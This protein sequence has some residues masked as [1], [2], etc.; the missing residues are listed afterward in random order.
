V[1]VRRSL[2]N[3]LRAREGVL[4]WFLLRSLCLGSEWRVSQKVLVCVP[5]ASLNTGAEGAR[6]DFA[7]GAYRVEI[8]RAREASSD[9]TDRISEMDV[10]V[11]C[12]TTR[13]GVGIVSCRYGW[14]DFFHSVFLVCTITIIVYV[15]FICA[16]PL[17]YF[18]SLLILF[19]SIF[20]SNSPLH[21]STRLALLDMT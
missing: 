1:G 9:W 8:V 21:I 5:V 6:S 2:G 15:S 3:V 19:L 18:S 14:G 11:G 4:F 20:L 10:H 7:G 12:R 13:Y 16:P 17:H